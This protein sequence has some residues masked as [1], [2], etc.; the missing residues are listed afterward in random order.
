ML[1]TARSLRG[2]VAAVAV[3]V[4]ATVGLTGCGSDDKS[5]TATSATSSANTTSAAAGTT[6]SGGHGGNHSDGAPTAEELQNTLAVFAA[7]DK[8]TADKVAVV[9]DGQKRAANIDQMTKLLAG[10]GALKFIVSD[11]KVDGATATAQTVISSPNGDAPPM[12]LTW[13]KVDGKWKIAD[14]SACVLLG[15]AQAPCTP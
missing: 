11:V 9:V 13:Q 10:Y 3:A 15:F 12:P 1:F 5:D 2:C 4:A 14:A 6:G 7:A 8:P